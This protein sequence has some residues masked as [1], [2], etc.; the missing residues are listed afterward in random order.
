MV[1]DLISD[2]HALGSLSF[3]G[4]REQCGLR[5]LNVHRGSKSDLLGFILEHDKMIGSLYGSIQ[6]MSLEIHRNHARI[7]A[8][9]LGDLTKELEKYNLSTWN[10]RRDREKARQRLHQQIAFCYS[11]ANRDIEVICEPAVAADQIE[12]GVAAVDPGWDGLSA[13]EW[14]RLSDVID[15]KMKMVCEEADDL[16]DTLSTSEEHKRFADDESPDVFVPAIE[17]SLKA[18]FVKRDVVCI[19]SSQRLPELVASCG[20]PC[21][22]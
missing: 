17:A 16:K 18:E 3:H 13:T 20:F 8:M 5:G 2:P 21:V 19:S 7:S 9:N 1:T 12:Q 15:A 10:A 11:Q 14:Q 4:Q 6:D 22:K